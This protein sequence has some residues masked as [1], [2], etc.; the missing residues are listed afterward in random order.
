MARAP[1]HLD[2]QVK[3]TNAT[4]LMR[5]FVQQSG[6]THKHVELTADITKAQHFTSHEARFSV[7]D[8]LANVHGWQGECLYSYVVVHMFGRR[9]FVKEVS[10]S[11]AS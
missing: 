4:D 2:L 5:S 6:K 8:Q 7:I 3:L 11:E 10:T 9:M 1:L